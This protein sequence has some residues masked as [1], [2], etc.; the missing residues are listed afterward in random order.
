MD[1]VCVTS[2]PAVI[3]REMT[4]ADFD[5]VGAL[6]TKGFAAWRDAAF[7]SLALR[8]LAERSAPAGMPQL[9]Y[10]LERCGAIVGVLLLI[11]SEWRE[12]GTLVR[13]CNVSSWY[14]E[15]E[16]R[17]YGTLLVRQ[18]LRHQ[19]VT[20]LNVTPAPETWTVLAAQGY[21]RYAAG[22]A[23]TLPLLARRGNPA[24]V[25]VADADIAP[26]PDLDPAEI[27]LLREHARWGCLNLICETQ[28]GR[29]PFVFGLRRRR[30]I[31]RFVYLLY[32]RGPDS[33]L[34]HARPLGIALARRG[35]FLLV[36][37]SEA[38][39]KGIPGWFEDGHP[40]FYRGTKAPPASDLAYTER[41]I[42]GA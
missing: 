21:T 19:D 15:P 37:D 3:C 20:Y 26:G 24:R 23:V 39:I 13:R 36:A 25:V 28:A 17:L 32:C 41:A 29:V 14:V 38:K 4:V 30:G 6:L 42:F 40:K 10:V 22:R 31:I 16:F 8:R 27:D 18:A 33:L 11:A 5:A 1:Q 9:G 2:R 12:A 7:W 35:I 34:A